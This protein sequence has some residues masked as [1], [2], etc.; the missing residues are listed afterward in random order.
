MSVSNNGQFTLNFLRLIELGGGQTGQA[1][2]DGLALRDAG[3]DNTTTKSCSQTGFLSVVVCATAF[4]QNSRTARNQLV[5]RFFTV[6]HLI[7][8]LSR[9]SQKYCHAEEVVLREWNLL[10]SDDQHWGMKHHWKYQ[11]YMWEGTLISQHNTTKHRSRLWSHTPLTVFIKTM[12][13][14]GWAP[15]AIS[16]YLPEH[17]W[18]SWWLPS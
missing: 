9:W 2:M 1:I 12:L 4:Y 16:W 14:M 7:A 15:N 18:L 3:L 5:A 11:D 8:P 6:R 17:P 13:C 10:I